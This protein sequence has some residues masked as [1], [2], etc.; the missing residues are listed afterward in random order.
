[1]HELP[2]AYVDFNFNGVLRVPRGRLDL[3]TRV[4]QGGLEELKRQGVEPADGLRA[5][6]YDLDAM[7]D[8]TPAFLE[9]DGSLF[10]DD[11][12]GEWLAAFEKGAFR[13]VPRTE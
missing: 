1:V 11:D 9:V 10:W 2:R 7:D 6:L 3:F 13:T 8:G 12:R 4:P 5:T